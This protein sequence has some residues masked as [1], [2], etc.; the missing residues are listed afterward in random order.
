MRFLHNT[1]LIQRSLRALGAACLWALSGCVPTAMPQSPQAESNDVPAQSAHAAVPEKP[2]HES[3]VVE[4]QDVEASGAFLSPLPRAV[5]SYG[6]AVSEGAFYMFGGYSGTPHAYSKEGQS[7]DVM[8]LELSGE[9]G[10][11]KVASLEHGLQG[12]VAVHHEGRVCIFGGNHATN[13][14]GEDSNMISQ[15]SARCLDTK[16]SEWQELPDLPRGRSSHGAAVVDGKVY[17]A[18][19]W[20]LSGAAS[21]GQFVSEMLA[22]DLE[23]PKA[24]W[25]S[26]EVPFA[27]RA[28]GVAAVGKKLFVVGG[29]TSKKEISKEVNVYDTSTKEWRKGPEHPGDAFGIAVAGNE[30]HLFASG[31]EGV[32]R[33][34]EPGAK[35]WKD[36]RHLGFARFFHEMRVSG[37]ELIVVGGIGGM[38]TR[39]R[40]R[41][42][43]RLP[44]DEETIAY[45]QMTFD[46]PAKAKN[47]QG[48]LLQGELL[49]LFG[50]NVSLGQ[51]DFGREHFTAEGWIF[52]QATLRFTEAKPY[53]LRRQSM[54]TL[55][56]EERGLSLGGFGHEPLTAPDSEALSHEEIFSYSFED[57]AW[58][59]SGKMP[60]GRTQ[61]GLARDSGQ[62]W[63]FGGLNYDPK[64]KNAFQH[65]TSI[66]VADEKELAFAESEVSLPGPRRAFAGASLGGKYYLVGGMKEGFQLV[67]DCLSF[68]FEKKSFS[69]IPCPAARLSGALIPAGDKLYL[70]GGSVKTEE[71]LEESRS[72]EVYDPAEK[73]WRKLDF[74][75]PFST[76]HM[77][78]LPY[79]EQILLLST[80]NEKQEMTIGLLNP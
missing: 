40:T 50:G 36:V 37:D 74:E 17:L 66:W 43:E 38:H 72:V 79:R 2:E 44:L 41:V 15:K 64:R 4:V 59:E 26:M 42:V 21:S 49:Y 14:E 65:D 56:L 46:I 5:T 20:T 39:G 25:E 3:R 69:E 57:Q 70:V 76:R 27:R 22:L 13:Q 63:I 9:G 51:H 34:L 68:D 10:W 58:T 33:S 62:V 32:L 31:R 35:E 80:H 60:R 8:K 18:G 52:D 61:F 45:G 16:T 30:T 47:R 29:M 11:E 19:G 54:Q 6:A 73:S 24:Q 28:V 78:A 23:D 55:S 75:I 67:D 7:T 1:P 53:P 71:G 48:L 77:R 12:L